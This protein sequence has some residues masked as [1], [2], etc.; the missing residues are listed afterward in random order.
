MKTSKCFNLR[1]GRETNEHIFKYLT[2]SDSISVSHIV[3]K[4]SLFNNYQALSTE[5]SYTD[6]K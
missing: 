2:Q 3:K 6:N 5:T 4:K 1:N